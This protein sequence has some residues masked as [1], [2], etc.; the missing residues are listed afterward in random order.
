MKSGAGE[1]MRLS[2]PFTIAAVSTGYVLL[3][4][5]WGGGTI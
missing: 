3:W 4:L 5:V 2:I 1:F